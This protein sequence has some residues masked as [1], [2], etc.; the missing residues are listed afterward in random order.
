MT[1][2]SIIALGVVQCVNWGV[3]YYAFGALLLPVQHDL[4][5]SQA[6]VAGAFSIALLVSAVIAPR[7]GRLCDAGY[8]VR[9]LQGGAVVSA[10]LLWMWALAPGVITLY[11]A[12][13]GL[14]GCMGATLYEPAFA[15]VGRSVANPRDRL[16]ALSTVT[17]FGGLASTAFLPA[18]AVLIDWWHWRVA[19]AALGVAM[20][21]S[22]SLS[23]MLR[24]LDRDC[25]VPIEKITEHTG[26]STRRL[27]AVT[28]LFSIASLASAAFAATAI[29]AFVERG[30]SATL[31]AALVGLF[32]LLQL[33]GRVML[34]A[35]LHESTSRLAVMSLSAQAI[36][37]GLI[38]IAPVGFIAVGVALF[39]M[40]NGVMTLIRPHVVQSAFGVASAGARNG[41]IARAQQFAR[42]LGPI[43]ATSLAGV[44]GYQITLTMMALALGTLAVWWRT[45]FDWS[46]TKAIEE[47]T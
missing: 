30:L 45:A 36:G 25:S 12:W 20:A 22:A 27:Q 39:A 23:A 26:S 5:I 6:M 42:A 31:A 40:G 33:P 21:V 10:L 18:T 38:A 44:V 9:L 29:A 37:L 35:G 3:L 1:R 8:G 24:G 15:I 32:G 19:V 17:V 47:V 28:V 41:A 46:E 43:G 2:R 7:I 34:M 4:G 16:R 11:L 14:G 13:V